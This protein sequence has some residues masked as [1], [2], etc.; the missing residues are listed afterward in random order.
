MGPGGARDGDELRDRGDYRNSER[1]GDFS[2]PPFRPRAARPSFYA[3]YTLY[4]HDARSTSRCSDLIK[5]PRFT[6]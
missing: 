6:L 4:T 1:G 5:V 2:F 3:L